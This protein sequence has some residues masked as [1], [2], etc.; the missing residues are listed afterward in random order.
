MY[1]LS[2]AAITLIVTFGGAL[3]GASLRKELPD[4]HFT[5]E[6]KEVM[7]LVLGL[8]STMAALVLGLLLASAQSSYSTQ[9]TNLQSMAANV[10]EIDRILGMYGAEAKDARALFKSIVATMHDSVWSAHHVQVD[11]L[12]PIRI[13]HQTRKYLDAVQGLEPRTQAQRFAQSQAIQLS[14]NVGQ[15]RLLMFERSNST[16]PRPFLVILLAW[17]CM[18]FIGFG[19][20]TSLHHTV[21]VVLFVGALSVSSTLFLILELGSPYNGLIQV[22]DTPL[23]EAIVQLG[24]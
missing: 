5:A 6:S 11:K 22:S 2:I 19:L 13:E 12:N 20:L 3:A 7:K 16:L 23:V 14:A 9:S 18:L 1:P 15:T 10:L 4:H 24:Q 21:T 17:V 8:L